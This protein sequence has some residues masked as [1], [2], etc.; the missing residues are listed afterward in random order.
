[1]TTIERNGNN[2]VV[3]AELLADAFGLSEATVQQGM[4]ENRIT[5]QSETGVE[6]DEGRWRL[7]FFFQDRAC[8]FIVDMHGQVLK[9]TS[10]PVRRRPA[11]EM[12]R[13][14]ASERE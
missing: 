6:E 8:R 13:V 1:M 10:F 4:R 2:F 11:H 14:P 5:S 3:P 12:R 9:R 7:T